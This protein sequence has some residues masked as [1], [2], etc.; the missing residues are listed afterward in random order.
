MQDEAEGLAVDLRQLATRRG[1]LVLGLGLVGSRVMADATCVAMAPETA[2]PFP[3][4]GS[5]A[6]GGVNALGIAGI[7]RS[8][9]RPSFGGLTGTATGLSVLLELQLVDVGRACA[10]L[11]GHAV[12]LWHCD[13]EGRYSIYDLP[14]VNYLRGVVE[15]D[16]RGVVLLTTV[17]PGCYPGRWP[18]L[19]FEVFRSGKAALAGEAAI[20]TS[21]LALPEAVCVSVYG[22]TPGY[23]ASKASFAGQKLEADQVFGDNSPAENQARMLSVKRDPMAGTS[24]VVVIGVA[25]TH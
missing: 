1:V 9:I 10:P 20:L 16:A 15:S 23:E 19:H 2:G 12:Y 22:T 21:Q 24:A 13:A 5:T 3:A 17:F 6:G 14:Q 8:D 11:A 18:H 25:L 4:D 7:S